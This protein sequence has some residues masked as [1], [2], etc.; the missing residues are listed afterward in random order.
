MALYR[1][2]CFPESGGC[3]KVALMLNLCGADWE[4]NYVDYFN[5]ETRTAKWREKDVS[6]PRSRLSTNTLDRMA[7]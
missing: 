3:Y 2:N 7:A 5:G 1:L 6:K 4:P